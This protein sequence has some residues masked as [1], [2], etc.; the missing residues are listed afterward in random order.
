MYQGYLTE[1]WETHYS[2]FGTYTRIGRIRFMLGIPFHHS[3]HFAAVEFDVVAEDVPPVLGQEFLRGFH[4]V[5]RYLEGSLTV[6]LD[7]DC[8]GKA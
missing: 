2:G 7:Q 6:T 1:P 4:G 8:E 5:H 3:S